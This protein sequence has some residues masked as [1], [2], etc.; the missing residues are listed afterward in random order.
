MSEPGPQN[1]L[2]NRVLALLENPKAK[3]AD[4]IAVL[5][6]GRTAGVSSATREWAAMAQEAL[7]KAEHVEGGI[8]LLKWRA[9]NTPGEQMSPKDWLRAA[10]LVAGSNPHLLALIQEAG[11]GQRLA[12]RE[13]VRRFRLLQSLKP[14]ALCLHRT[15]G[16][17]VVQKADSLY[18][19]IDINFRGRPGHGL[20]MKVAA[21]TLEVLGPDHLLA[22]MHQDREA[23]QRRHRQERF[24]LLARELGAEQA[25]GDQFGMRTTNPERDAQS[26]R[27]R[28]DLARAEA[29]ELRTIPINEAARVIKAK[30]A[31]QERMRRQATQRAQQLDPSERDPRRSGPRDNGPARGM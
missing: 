18:K 9:E 30:H 20:A 22:R 11:F 4:W 10:D 12:A 5:E 26:A 31:E 14:G 19:K 7:A 17:G 24:A 6:A 1:E 15:W 2:E 21:E 23:M 27:T 29:N 25:R 28:A 3:A 8:E 16:F 13:C